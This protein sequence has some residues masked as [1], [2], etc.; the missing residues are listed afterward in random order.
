M[1]LQ[2]KLVE[3]RTSEPRLVRST[4]VRYIQFQVTYLQYSGL[5]TP[6]TGVYT[7]IIVRVH[8]VF[9]ERSASATR[10]LFFVSS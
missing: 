1:L 2:L 7:V 8:L 5:R 9:D 6:N 4:G 10:V 3:S